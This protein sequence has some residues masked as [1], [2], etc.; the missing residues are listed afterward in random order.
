MEDL[1]RAA[2]APSLEL[3]IAPQ[4]TVLLQADYLEGRR[5]TDFGIPAFKGR[6]VDVPASRYYGAANARDADYSQS[7]VYSGTV[8]INHRFNDD[9]SIRNATRYYHDSLDRNNTLTSSVNE[10]TQRLTMSHSNVY[11]E[12]HGWFNQTDLTQKSIQEA[13]F[14]A[15]PR[16]L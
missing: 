3:R 7:R 4:T 6:P 10:V 14:P 9:W 8:T 13:E 1:D 12:E 5:A 2:V 11:R 16:T 15:L